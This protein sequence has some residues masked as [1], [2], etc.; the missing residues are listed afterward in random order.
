MGQDYL[1]EAAK[2]GRNV[3][4]GVLFKVVVCIFGRR[5]TSVTDL[6]ASQC[7]ISL[8][9]AA[10]CELKLEKEILHLELADRSKV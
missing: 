10:L 8:E 2:V 3:S 1:E 6:G 7:Y 9:A 4:D 5:F